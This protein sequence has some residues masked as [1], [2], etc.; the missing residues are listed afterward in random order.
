MDKEDN[1]KKEVWYSSI[2]K[3]IEDK[4][5]DEE[6]SGLLSKIF[7]MNKRLTAE[8]ANMISRF[9]VPS[10][11]EDIVEKKI[12]EI[13]QQI[14]MKLQYSSQERLL[15]LVIPPDQVDLFE[16]IKQYYEDKGFKTFYV[17]NDR[18]PELRDSNYLFISWDLEIKKN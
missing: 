2:L 5:R 7:K 12:E 1:T 13:E 15:A 3:D 18:V 11:F 8:E 16:V 10:S 17:G 14:R 6:Y 4:H 9:G